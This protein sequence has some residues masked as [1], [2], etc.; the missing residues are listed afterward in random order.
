MINFGKLR[1]IRSKIAQLRSFQKTCTFPFNPDGDILNLTVFGSWAKLRA[2][3]RLS[4]TDPTP[5]ISLNAYC[6]APPTLTDDELSELSKKIEPPNRN[7]MST[8]TL[9]KLDMNK[10]SNSGRGEGPLSSSSLHTSI[11]MSPYT[12]AAQSPNGSTELPGSSPISPI[13]NPSRVPF[14]SAPMLN[15]SSSPPSPS[16]SALNANPPIS[17]N[18]KTYSE[19]NT[20][21]TSVFI[22]NQEKFDELASGNQN[23]NKPTP[24]SRISVNK[25]I[26]MPT[27]AIST[28]TSISSGQR[29]ST[30]QQILQENESQP[31]SNTNTNSVYEPIKS[32]FSKDS[33]VRIN[34]IEPD[35]VDG[36]TDG[37]INAKNPTP[38]NNIRT[39]PTSGSMSITTPTESSST[40][41]TSPSQPVIRPPPSPL[42]PV[43]RK[44]S[45]PP[46]PLPT[47]PPPKRPS[48]VNTNA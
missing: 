31:Q 30:V 22:P 39:P 5:Y 2:Q 19:T 26:S 43:I 41:S 11:S 25:S 34:I 20:T 13:T 14:T 6:Y 24:A 27:V 40:S 16:S 32:D 46:P 38:N 28:S 36:A 17:P 47:A 3:G 4:S 8:S 37:R 23:N 45:G 9:N 10:L 33:G 48:T 12:T 15:I 35:I 42:P 44:P 29:P 7:A 1:H 21:P 18:T